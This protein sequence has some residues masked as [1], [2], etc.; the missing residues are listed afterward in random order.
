LSQS[1]VDCLLPTIFVQKNFNL[2]IEEDF[3]RI[4]NEKN[5][6]Y[7]KIIAHPYLQ[8]QNN[9]TDNNSDNNLNS[10][11]LNEQRFF[12]F[13][14]NNRNKNK[15]ENNNENINNIINSS[16]KDE[17]NIYNDDEVN[18][19]INNYNNNNNETVKLQYKVENNNNK[20]KR[21]EK[22]VIAIGPEGGWEENEVFLFEKKNFK[23]I[24]LGKRI[25]RTDIAVFCFFIII[26][27]LFSFKF[28]FMICSYTIWYICTQYIYCV[29]FY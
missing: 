3:D 23:R 6:F 9:G 15:T 18:N 11:I 8:Q 21:K 5:V 7:H 22:I 25:L 16:N 13:I 17:N 24:S 26:Y 4:F 29:F 12:D 2:F 20:N 10:I 14:M 1:S 28:F 27:I 19:N